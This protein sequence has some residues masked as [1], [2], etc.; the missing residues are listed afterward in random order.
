MRRQGQN[1]EASSIDAHNGMCELLKREQPQAAHIIYGR[2]I[3]RLTQICAEEKAFDNYI[4]ST[5]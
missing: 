4:D 2:E 5:E 3:I 1:L